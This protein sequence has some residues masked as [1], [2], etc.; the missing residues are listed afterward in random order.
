MAEPLCL[1]CQ[2]RDRR[3]AE[4]ER[5]VADLEATVRDLHAR[6]G[7]NSSNSS[8][9]PSA[10]PLDAPPPV[11]KQPTGRKRGGQAGHPGHTRPLLPPEQVRQTITYIP[12]TCQRCHAPLPATAGPRDPEPIRHQVIELPPVTAYA[13]EYQ[14]HGR[15]CPCCGTVTWEK[16]PD[17]VR[18]QGFGPFCTAVVGYLSAVPH[19]SKR[20]IQEVFAAVFRA[21]VALGSVT[22]IEQEVS[23]ALAPAH[24]EALAAV[25]EAPVKHADATG[26][27]DHGWLWAAATATVVC[28]VIHPKRGLA[29]LL[30][31]LGTK[32]KGILCSDRWAVYARWLARCR[33]VCWAH[34]KRDFQ[35]VVD[36]GGP[37]QEVGEAGLACVRV[38]FHWWHTYRGGGISRQ[39]LQQ[40]LEPVRA[41]L[42]AW[43]RHGCACAESKV[44]NF[45]TNLLQ[46]EPA[47]WTF[48]YKDGVEP[49]NNHMERLLRTGVLWRK[50]SFG[51]DSEAGC[52]FVERSLT[53]VQ[54]L[55]LQ[56][57][58]V[59]AFLHESV[60]AHRLGQPGPR[61]V[62]TG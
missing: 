56:K 8:V 38:L 62:I 54:T 24:A 4:L 40:E 28:F 26:W 16:I 55:R 42:A 32:I 31:L 15:T 7:Q 27:E 44:A 30:A 23:A 9:P 33:H 46:L 45:C 43:L 51:C 29:G 11:V 10:N 22:N 61:L 5:R 47:L 21:P 53:V 57:R 19:I 60:V 52:R 14:A 18:A 48:L 17:T 35:K 37:G 6:L 41:V 39:E 36:R 59:L 58:S 13:I 2:Q 1:G 3:I 12:V 20:G 50:I 25:R 34:L 49:T